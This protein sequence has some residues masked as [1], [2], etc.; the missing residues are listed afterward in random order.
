MNLSQHPLL[1]SAYELSVEVDKLPAHVDQTALITALGEWRKQL[2]EHLEK[3][4]L[5][6]PTGTASL[7]SETAWIP[8][9]DR[10]PAIGKNVA[11]LISDPSVAIEDWPTSGYLYQDNG[12]WAGLPGK[13]I[14][15]A[16]YN[17]KVTHWM[18]LPEAPK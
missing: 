14:N 3:H 18:D 8:V 11:L 9:A 6:L 17:W 15:L 10:L 16:G 1:M 7:R 2:A 13:Y 12:W 5:L 4:G